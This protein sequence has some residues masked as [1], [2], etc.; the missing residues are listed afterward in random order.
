MS[1]HILYFHYVFVTRRRMNCIA[2]L[3]RGKSGQ[4]D[5]PAHKMR[6]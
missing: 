2:R 1:M 6:K 5:I 3:N 4:V